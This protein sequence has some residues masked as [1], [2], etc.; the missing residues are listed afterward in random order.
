[1]QTMKTA[2]QIRATTKYDSQN[3]DKITL[4]VRKDREPTRETI[5]AAADAAGVSVNSFVMEAVREKIGPEK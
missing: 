5:K 4:M 2:A 3:Y 1:M